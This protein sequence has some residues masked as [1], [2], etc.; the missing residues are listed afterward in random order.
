MGSGVCG[1]YGPGDRKLLICLGPG[2]LRSFKSGL[3][4]SWTVEILRAGSGCPSRNTL[5]FA[6]HYPLY[7]PSLGNENF[8]A[9]STVVSNSPSPSPRPHPTLPRR[10]P[11]V[12]RLHPP[13]HLARSH[14]LRTARVQ[15]VQRLS[16]S[17]AAVRP[18]PTGS[19]ERRIQNEVQ[20]GQ[21]K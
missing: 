10:L 17:S 5:I 21:R 16:Y 14:L 12:L 20:K 18:S 1:W 11:L 6:V 8:T 13:L 3:A 4:S 7:R 19:N 9:H 15:P 2:R